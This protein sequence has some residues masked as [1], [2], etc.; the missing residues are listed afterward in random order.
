MSDSDSAALRDLFD[1]AAGFVESGE[2][3]SIQVAVA[4]DGEIVRGATFGAANDALFVSY[5]I[6]KA[7]T[8][9]LIWLLVQ[10]GALSYDNPVST[11]IPAFARDGKHVITLRHLLTHTAGLPEA[12]FH[13]LDFDDPGRRDERFDSWSLEWAPGSRY[14]YHRASAMWALAEVIRVVTGAT[15][16]E[17]FQNRVA[18]PLGLAD[19]F[20][21]STVE[22]PIPHE[23]V[24]MV[25][26]V[27]TGLTPEEQEMMGLKLSFLGPEYERYL[28]LYNRPDVRD[29]GAPGAGCITSA[30]SIALFY[31]GLLGRRERIWSAD[32]LGEALS[33]QTGDLADPMT[34]RQAHRGLGV[35][36]SGDDERIFRGFA[37]S[38]S[39]HAFGHPGIGGQVAWADP[40]SG[41]SF[42]LLTSGLERNPLQLGMRGLQLSEAAATLRAQ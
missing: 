10:D 5:S 27:G 14:T 29:V 9:S 37:P 13:A 28:S 21:G 3:P 41:I 7:I 18:G 23:R 42:C 17:F 26:H 24:A 34:G 25:E 20:L 12:A 30:A 15:H 35:V 38:H 22:A 4:R 16:R 1:T 11:W 6:T 36:L 33:L 19:A 32:T 31:Q 40:A 2:L 8:S 39:P